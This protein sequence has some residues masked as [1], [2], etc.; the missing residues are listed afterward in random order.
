MKK[1]KAYWII[2]P[3]SRKLSLQLTSFTSKKVYKK[4]THVLP[5]DAVLP[6]RD[7]D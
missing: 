4:T 3:K 5:V 7:Y 6:F 1:L 2:Y